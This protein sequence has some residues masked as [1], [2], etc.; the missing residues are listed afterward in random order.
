MDYLPTLL[1]SDSVSDLALRVRAQGT[2]VSLGLRQAYDHDQKLAIDAICQY[3]EHARTIE[4]CSNLSD[5]YA[6]LE[7]WGYVPR[8]VPPQP[9]YIGRL[10]EFD[11]GHGG[12]STVTDFLRLNADDP[13]A[14]EFVRGLRVGDICTIGG[15]AEALTVVRRIQ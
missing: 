6:L 2:A 14:C 7:R 1:G 15:G 11:D 10:L 8:P 5:A 4:R 3:E 9:E 12:H 13:D